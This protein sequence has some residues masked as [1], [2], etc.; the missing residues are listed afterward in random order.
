MSIN[1]GRYKPETGDGVTWA[2]VKLHREFLVLVK[3]LTTTLVPTFCVF[4]GGAGFAMATQLQSH[5]SN[6]TVADLPRLAQEGY[7]SFGCS[8]GYLALGYQT[9]V[10]AWLD[11]K[12]ANVTANVSEAWKKEWAGKKHGGRHG[13]AH[14][15]RRLKESQSC[16]IFA[17]LLRYRWQWPVPSYTFGASWGWNITHFD[18]ASMLEGVEAVKTRF[19]SRDWGDNTT[20]QTFCI[21]ESLSQYFGTAYMW[22]WP[23]FTV[24][25]FGLL[26]RVL[27][28]SK[29]SDARAI[30][31]QAALTHEESLVDY[32]FPQS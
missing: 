10:P 11:L 12:K 26:D 16:G 27:V 28:I 32:M 13:G 20:A 4:F 9:G 5:A 21:T 15:H 6:C 23:I 19:P 3:A 18:H 1:R 31:D 24:L 17:D 30:F 25:I 22:R 2:C 8:G 7:M 14:H 29:V